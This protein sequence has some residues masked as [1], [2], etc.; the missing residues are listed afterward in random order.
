MEIRNQLRHLDK[1]KLFDVVTVAVEND[2]AELVEAVE[3][4]PRAFAIGDDTIKRQIAAKRWERS[5]YHAQYQERVRA[6]SV[7]ERISA[8]VRAVLA[9]LPES[10][11]SR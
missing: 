1:S 11:V 9:A 7:R 10:G 2:D 5:G 6:A 3:T 4:A 8:K